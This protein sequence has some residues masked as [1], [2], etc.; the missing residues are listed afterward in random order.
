MPFGKL[1]LIIK[2]NVILP[3]H[4]KTIHIPPTPQPPKPTLSLLPPCPPLTPPCPPDLHPQRHILIPVA[5]HRPLPPLLLALHSINFLYHSYGTSIPK[6]ITSIIKLLFWYRYIAHSR[7]KGGTGQGRGPLGLEEGGICA[8]W[9]GGGRGGHG[10][11]QLGGVWGWF[12]G[13]KGKVYCFGWWWWR[14]KKSNPCKKGWW[15]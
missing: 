4:A 15:A 6:S 1:I 12:L 3:R 7:Y 5:P 11:V 2:E 8:V 14:V 13:E 10:G 9:G